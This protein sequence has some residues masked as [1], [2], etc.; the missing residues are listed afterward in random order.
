MKTRIY[1]APAVKWLTKQDRGLNMDAN[2]WSDVA[3]L[4]LLTQATERDS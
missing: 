4:G 3:E 1:A 2:G